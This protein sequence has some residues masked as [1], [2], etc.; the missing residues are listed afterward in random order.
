MKKVIKKTDEEFAILQEFWKILQDFYE[1]EDTD[2]YWDKLL[3]NTIK[4]ERDHPHNLLCEQLILLIL[5]YLEKKF[6]QDKTSSYAKLLAKVR[7]AY[8]DFVEVADEKDKEI[9]KEVL[10]SNEGITE[11]QLILKARQLHNQDSVE[12]LSMFLGV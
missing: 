11:Q 3:N 4:F 1:P 12:Q 2:E 8:T 10:D 5:N 7:W 9:L 6:K